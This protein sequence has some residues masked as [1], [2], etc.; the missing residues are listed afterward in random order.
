MNIK[1]I[2]NNS[3][4]EIVD[5]VSY[6]DREGFVIVCLSDDLYAYAKNEILQKGRY[7]NVYPYSEGLALVRLKNDQLAF[8]DTDGDI[9][10]KLKKIKFHN[11]STSFNNG[12]VWIQLED[13]K[14]AFMD[15][16]GN[17]QDGRY[18]GAKNYS[19]GLAAV[20]LE[21]GQWAYIDEKGNLRPGRYT[22]AGEYK[23]GLA[24]VKIYDEEVIIDKLGYIQRTEKLGYNQNL[25]LSLWVELI[26]RE[27][28][29]YKWIPLSCFNEEFT[30]TIRQT[31]KDTLIKGVND[32]K[33]SEAKQSS[34]KLEE[35]LDYFTEVMKIVAE[36]NKEVEA[37]LKREAGFED[38]KKELLDRIEDEFGDNV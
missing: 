9:R 2:I 21:D 14:Y 8:I 16:N 30:K 1:D 3:K 15:R 5:I 20:Q 12:L 37:Y 28:R 4:D 34:A 13:G 38:Q 7:K 26:K 36:K 17:L 22:K 29:L 19:E 32:L 33:Y 11:I 25:D 31:I 27:P 23:S 35:N 24:V 10:I 6:T 18:N